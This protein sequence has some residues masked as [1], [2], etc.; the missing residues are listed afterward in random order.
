M[1]AP[2]GPSRWAPDK[3]GD[4]IPLT[5]DLVAEVIYDQVIAHRFRHGTR[6]HRWRPDKGPE[7]C[8]LDQLVREVQ[9]KELIQLMGKG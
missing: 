7:Q 4:Y 1:E 5:H 6:F 8:T 3:S 9:P 2:G